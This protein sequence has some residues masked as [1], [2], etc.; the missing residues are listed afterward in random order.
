[1]SSAIEV[2]GL[3]KI[4]GQ[5]QRGVT[6][7]LAVDHIDFE[8]RSGEIF[9]FLG[10]NGAGKTTTHRMLTTLLEPPADLRDVDPAVNDGLED[11]PAVPPP[12]VVE[13]SSAGLSFSLPVYPE[14]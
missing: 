12:H 2:E 5:G 14:S 3:T 11:V 4:Y 9:G 7:V 6:S 13:A 1:M 10:P 8:V